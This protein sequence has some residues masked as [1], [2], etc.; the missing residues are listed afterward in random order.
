MY[1]S[2][3]MLK[4]VLLCRVGQQ[5]VFFSF[6]VFTEFLRQ[7][8][9]VWF[10]RTL[11]ELQLGPKWSVGSKNSKSKSCIKISIF[12]TVSS[13]FYHNENHECVPSALRELHYG[14]KWWRNQ[15]RK[16][17]TRA[18]RIQIS[19][20]FVEK[21]LLFKK[22]SLAIYAGQKIFLRKRASNKMP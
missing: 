10:W 20:K 1:A 9:C 13:Q 15:D 17:T 4:V 18:D 14:P 21:L 7:N 22:K 6:Q 5:L 16:N 3:T 2:Y 12:L 8:V 19:W 11:G